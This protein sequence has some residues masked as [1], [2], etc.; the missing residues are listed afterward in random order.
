MKITIDISAEEIV[1]LASNGIDIRKFI[2][3][4]H[5]D[6][7]NIDDIVAVRKAVVDSGYI[8]RFDT[9]ETMEGFYSGKVKV[10]DGINFKGEI[11]INGFSF[12]LT[13]PCSLPDKDQY[14]SMRISWRF[15]D[16]A[17]RETAIGAI[18]RLCTFSL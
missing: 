10:Y 8:V 7:R 17:A 9:Y 11:M 2:E 6:S 13:N 1:K 14:K 18:K 5:E 4:E 3:D 12:K 15:N 16:S